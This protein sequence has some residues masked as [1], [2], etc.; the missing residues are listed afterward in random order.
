VPKKEKKYQIIFT[1]SRAMTKEEIVEE[2]GERIEITEEDDPV[3]MLTQ[4][5]N[6]EGIGF[7][8]EETITDWDHSV[9]DKEV[10]EK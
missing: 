7:F 2:Y 4:F 6:D 3:E 8:N 9:D 5:M 10:K 1:A